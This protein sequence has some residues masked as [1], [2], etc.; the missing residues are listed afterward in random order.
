VAATADDDQVA[1]ATPRLFGE[2]RRRATADDDRI[3]VQARTLD[4]RLGFL[5]GALPLCHDCRLESFRRDHGRGWPCPPDERDL[6]LD[7]LDDHHLRPGWPSRPRDEIDTDAC[8]VGAIGAQDDP[9]GS[10]SRRPTLFAHR[11]SSSR[12]GFSTTRRGLAAAGRRRSVRGA[13]GV[14]LQR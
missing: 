8:R 5:D 14:T 7:G 2:H 12:G 4:T 3:H 11:L 13:C 10:A 1:V 9:H 6:R